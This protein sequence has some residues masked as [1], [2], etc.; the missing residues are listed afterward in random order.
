MGGQRGSSRRGD[1]S[2][3]ATPRLDKVRLVGADGAPLYVDVRTGA[4]LGE[5]RPTV[6][7]CHGFKGFKDWGFFP[8]LAE[9]LALA[10]FT[11][12]SFNFSGSGVGA[13]EEFDGLER[14]TRQRPTADLEDLRAVVDFAA[15]GGTSWIGLVGHSRGGGLSI[16]HAATDPR[17][18]ALVTWAAIDTFERWPEEELQRWR[19]EGKLDVV[20]ARTGQVLPISLGA[21]EDIEAHRQDMLDIRRAAGRVR[22]PWLIVH[23]TA[24]TSVGPAEAERLKEWSAEAELWLV[25]GAGHTFGARHPL[26]GT[27]PELTAVMDRTVR[28]LSDTLP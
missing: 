21:L 15:H 4:R 11:A 5:S 16:L 6:V 24:D 12:V 7:I 13:G 25:E 2:P 26:A 28:F 20:N 3:V 10:G 8:R 22:A 9:R 19:A 14:W 17:I 23:G 18:R 27:T 1:Y